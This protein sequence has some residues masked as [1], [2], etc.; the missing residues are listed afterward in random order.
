MLD[1][2]RTG[3]GLLPNSHT[4]TATVSTA[5]TPQHEQDNNVPLSVGVSL[6]NPGTASQGLDPGLG[7]PRLHNL[8]C[9]SVRCQYRR[10]TLMRIPLSNG[11]G[12]AKRVV[13]NYE[14]DNNWTLVVGAELPDRSTTMDWY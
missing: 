13:E 12:R 6:L 10:K 7:A 14:R 2:P 4:Q 3:P 1:A 5:L 11:N 8:S 9:T